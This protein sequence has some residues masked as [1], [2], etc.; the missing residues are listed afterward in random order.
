MAGAGAT[1]VFKTEVEVGPTALIT[2]GSILLVLA[3]MGRRITSIGLT[4]G[5]IDWTVEQ[6]RRDLASAK[7]DTERVEIVTAAVEERPRIRNI[8][9]IAIN[10]ERAYFNVI[11]DRLV[12]HFGEDAVATDAQLGPGL[13]RADL[14]VTKGGK[15]VI[16]E[17]M[18]GAPNRA[19]NALQMMGSSTRPFSVPSKP[20]PS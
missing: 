2:I 5:K 14:I 16:V 4:E 19:L 20:T 10:S 12:G 7:D 15:S 3:V 9:D 17:A 6:V 11:R 18:F 13:S 1:A 8:L